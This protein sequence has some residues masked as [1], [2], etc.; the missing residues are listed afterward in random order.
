MLLIILIIIILFYIVN[1][2]LLN[3]EKK[4]HFLTFYLPFYDKKLNSLSNFYESK[5][6][7]LNYFK[8]KFIYETITMCSIKLDQYF[9]TTLMSFYISNTNL[10][11]VRI[12]LSDNNIQNI[13][14][15]I[16]NKINY[17]V[18]D[19]SAI[20]YVNSVLKINTSN[21][22]LV[23][24]LYRLYH[25]FMTKKRYKV[26]SLNEIPPDFIIGL[27][28]YPNPLYLYFFKLMKDLG[29]NVKTDFKIKKYKTYDSLFEGFLKSECN[30]I[31]I[32]YIFPSK[33]LNNFINENILEDI[34]LLPFDI[35]NEDLFLKKNKNLYI[36]YI[37]LNKLSQLYLPKNFSKYTYNI[38]KPDFKVFYSK[39]SLI[40]NINAPEDRTYNFINFYYKNYRNINN[41][42]SDEG[43][44][45]HKTDMLNTYNELDFHVGVLKFFIEK[46]YISTNSDPNCKYLVGSLECNNK[47][48][49]NNNLL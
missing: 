25:F 21:I 29:Y 34:I 16:N 47:N 4:E 38:Y 2:Y 40:T 23:T 15:L 39:K 5:D 12:K 14:D 26:Y 6:N 24:N 10:I 35:V 31:I 42:V 22:K 27:V 7:N 20:N 30:M 18:T 17:L 46:G 3:I 41:N 48:L 28:D 13:I 19:I 11:N 37:D 32:C 49:A 44:Q 9:I 43:Y 36:D 45:L 33:V 8:K 1:N